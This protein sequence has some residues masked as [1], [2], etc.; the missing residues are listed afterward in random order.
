[1]VTMVLL[2]VEL[3]CA[4]PVWTFFLT[5][6]LACRF[7]CAITG[8]SLLGGGGRALLLHRLPPRSL[9]RARIRVRALA[10]DRQPAA[11]AQPAVAA[12]VH[13]PLDRHRHIAPQV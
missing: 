10:A 4:T 5:L 3:M 11:V 13:Q 9:A 6:R 1:M 7:G 8:S 12:E 2:K